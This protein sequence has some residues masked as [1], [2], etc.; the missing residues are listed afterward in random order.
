MTTDTLESVA[1]A[2]EAQ[3]ADSPAAAFDFATVGDTSNHAWH[4][5]NPQTDEPITEVTFFIA[6][7]DT[8]KYR[9]VIAAAQQAQARR[10]QRAKDGASY[11]QFSMDVAVG[12]VLE[13]EGVI[14]NGAP[15][16]CT[17]NNKRMLFE[18]R[19][20]LYDQ[21][22]EFIGSREQRLGKR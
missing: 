22:R 5:T 13:W 17:D 16:P 10:I 14:W 18:A 2:P 12:V 15:L 6:G 11:D 3:P 1:E 21:L 9:K 8:P 7:E 20:W 4:P 19:R